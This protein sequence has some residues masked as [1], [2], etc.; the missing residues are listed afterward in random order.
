MFK[1]IILS[2]MDC[3][4]VFQ[5][6]IRNKESSDFPVD[7]KM[8]VTEIKNYW[9]EFGHKKSDYD[10]NL[11]TEAFIKATEKNIIKST[12]F[13]LPMVYG[14]NDY[15]YPHRHGEII[16]RIFDKSS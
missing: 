13:R 1:L 11:V 7:E 16:K 2:S 10:K 12:I 3:Y 6:L 8:P 5:K 4:D 14:P 15:Q 9:G